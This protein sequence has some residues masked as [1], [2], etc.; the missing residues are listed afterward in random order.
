MIHLAREVGEIWR[1]A[2][3]SYFIFI[4]EFKYGQTWKTSL[5]PLTGCLA[6]PENPEIILVDPKNPDFRKM[7]S[8]GPKK[9]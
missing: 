2:C 8:P 1:F 9:S 7:L 5:F 4:Y 6:D 3:C